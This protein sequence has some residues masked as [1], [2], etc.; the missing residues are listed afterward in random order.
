MRVARSSMMRRAADR[1]AR[2]RPRSLRRLGYA[3]YLVVSVLLGTE[4]LLR[5]LDPIGMSY[6]FEVRKYFGEMMIPDER[7]AYIH[8]PGLAAT[9]QGVDVSINRHGFRGPGFPA[10]KP[11]GKARM[12]I[13]GDSVVFGW[14]VEQE[15][16][17]PSLLQRG[18][19]RLGIPVEIV[20]AG[21]GSWNTRTQYEWLRHVGV[22]LEPDIILLMIVAND[23]DPNLAGATAVRKAELSAATADRSLQ[24]GFVAFWRSALKS[25]YLAA[26]LKYF[27]EERLLTRQAGSIDEHSPRWRDARLALD[28]LIDLCRRRG[29][30]LIAY[31][32]GSEDT[33]RRY[34]SLKLYRDHFAARGI[35]PLMT[36]A[37]LAQPRFQNSPVDP[38]LNA[39]GHAILAATILDR[40][41]PRLAARP[42]DFAPAEAARREVAP[43]D[44]GPGEASRTAAPVAL[45][46][47]AKPR[48]APSAAARP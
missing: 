16:I 5:W 11:A 4:I 34:H 47:P 9:V 18:I 8:K 23:V 48:G 15:A 25:S 13:L 43:D 24:G 22:G 20:A 35:R 45:I 36:S 29:I 38:H 21:V 7:F 6:V 41:A 37:I 40:L 27:H 19:D 10:E 3:A 12:M 46:P 1:S 32:Y 42:P 2:R 39:A 17:F 26:H 28:G 31:L 33:I 44:P 30:E 14:G